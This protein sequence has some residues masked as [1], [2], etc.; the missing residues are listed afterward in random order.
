MADRTATK[1]HSAEEH[2]IFSQLL[3]SPYEALL[4]RLHAE[5]AAAGYA[6]PKVFEHG[7]EILGTRSLRR[8]A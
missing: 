4:T 5:L 8:A 1:E 3:R 7:S 2:V 6:T